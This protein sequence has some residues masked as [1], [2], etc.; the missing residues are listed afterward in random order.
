MKKLSHE[1]LKK[2][3]NLGF[4]DLLRGNPCCGLWN[5]PN[6]ICRT[7]TFPDYIALYSQPGDYARTPNT[8]VSFAQFDN[9]IDG[10]DGLYQAIRYDQKDQLQKFKERFRGAAY[11]I[12]PDISQFV[13]APLWLNLE[14]LAHA[15]IVGL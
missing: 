14:N 8:A 1:P 5:L 4:L 10:P 9:V 2:K 3:F 7:R 15:R 6:I 12:T 13:D 11:I